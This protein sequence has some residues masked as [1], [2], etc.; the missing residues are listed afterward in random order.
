MATSDGYEAIKAEKIVD[1]ALSLLVRRSVLG[2][3][4]FRNAGGDFRGAKDDAITLR[5]PAYAKPGK[6]AL[7]SDTA[8][9]RRKLHERKVVLEL[10]DGYN[11]DV[12][13]TDEERDLD[14]ENLSREIIAP[15]VEGIAREYESDIGDLMS[16]AS[17][18][19]DTVEIT[20]DPYK[21]AVLARKALADGQVPLEGLFL[22]VGSSVEA[23]ILGHDKLS[24][25]DQ[26]G[27]PDALRRAEIG[28]FANFTVVTA[29]A[30]PPDEAVAYHRTAFA[31]STRAPSVPDGAA[32]GAS[33]NADGYAVRVMQHLRDDDND[34]PVNMV[35]H[36]AWVGMKAVTDNGAIDPTTDKFE[37]SIDPDESGADDLFVRAVKLELAS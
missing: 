27:S 3:T 9:T 11:L 25:V 22:A 33:R 35:Y 4:V 32:W 28:R 20:N 15:S 34:G 23:E 7:R 26:S 8:R 19:R 37:P 5:L 29:Q 21:A 18:A 17:Y 24:T 16:T 31:V 10:T 6:R 14:I 1:G 2:R 12:P 36:D 13:L 30:L